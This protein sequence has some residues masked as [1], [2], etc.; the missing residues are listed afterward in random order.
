MCGEN[1]SATVDSLREF[2]S[3]PRVRGK[4][5][6]ERDRANAAG[7]IPACAGKTGDLKEHL[8]QGWAHPRVC[9]ENSATSPPFSTLNGSSPRVRG[10]HV[11]ACLPDLEDRLI[12]ACAGKTL[13]LVLSLENNGA[14]PRVCGENRAMPDLALPLVGSSPRVRGKLYAFRMSTTNL[15]L[16]PACAG[17]TARIVLDGASRPAHPRVCG[18][19]RGVR[20]FFGRRLGS[21]PRVRGKRSRRPRSLPAG[22]LIPACAGKTA[23]KQSR[24]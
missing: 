15:G 18:E 20:L 12:P 21:S 1:G 10:K 8:A 17:K 14:H 2:G 19:N 24:L 3:S 7:L 23:W 22:G 16:I 9:G 4:P 13:P 11:R 6:L 5:T